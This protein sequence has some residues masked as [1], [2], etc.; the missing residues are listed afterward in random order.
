IGR[1]EEARDLYRHDVMTAERRE[2][3][4]ADRTEKAEQERDSVQ[5]AM[6]RAIEE[7]LRLRTENPRPEKYDAHAEAAE[8]VG[9]LLR[10]RT[11]DLVEALAERDKARRE[12][13]HAHKSLKES[14]AALR[15]MRETPRPLTADDI[16]D[17]MVK[18]GAERFRGL[19]T[20]LS[21][22]ARV[23]TIIRA[24]LTPP[25]SRPEGAEGLDEVLRTFP[26]TLAGIRD[27]SDH[28]ASHGIRAGGDS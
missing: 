22:H 28:L 15:E 2:Q 21:A 19:P 3:E 20:A 5:A 10:A 17:E 14:D 8:K 6:S 18:R 27:I 16:T 9:A 23:R 4:F 25:P 12:R 26:G 24:A 13:D 1:V 7:N 11:V